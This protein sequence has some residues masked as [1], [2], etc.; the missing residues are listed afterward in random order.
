MNRGI[1]RDTGK[2][3]GRAA[4][5]RW[6][7]LVYDDVVGIDHDIEALLGLLQKRLGGTRTSASVE[8]VRVLSS[9]A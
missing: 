5:D 9:V 2:A 1:I 7:S 4:K 3:T 6:T 8:L